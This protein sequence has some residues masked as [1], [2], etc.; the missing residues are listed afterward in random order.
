[1]IP[2]EHFVTKSHHSSEKSLDPVM[3]PLLIH[4]FTGMPMR[5][6]TSQFKPASRVV[7]GPAKSETF[8]C[9]PVLC[10]PVGNCKL[11]SGGRWLS[12]YIFLRPTFVSSLSWCRSWGSGSWVSYLLSNARWWVLGGWLW[13]SVLMSRWK[14]TDRDRRSAIYSTHLWMLWR[15]HFLECCVDLGIVVTSQECLKL[16]VI[17][18]TWDLGLGC[19]HLKPSVPWYETSNRPRKGVMNSKM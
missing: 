2:S 5:I 7:Q 6:E 13:E 4:W 1:M 18:N 16:P 3:E 14:T 10:I 9:N 15:S 8:Y 19:C 12:R 11:P 17:S